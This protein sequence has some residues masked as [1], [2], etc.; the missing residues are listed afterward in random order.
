MADEGDDTVT[1]STAEDLEF[2]EQWWTTLKPL[3]P[4]P[5]SADAKAKE[6]INLADSSGATSSMPNANESTFEDEDDAWNH[7]PSR[8]STQAWAEAQELREFLGDMARMEEYWAEKDRAVAQEQQKAKAAQEWDD[9]AMYEA[10]EESKAPPKRRRMVAR[11]FAGDQPINTAPAS[12]H[13]V[14]I[15]HSGVIQLQLHF[16]DNDGVDSDASTRRLSTGDWPEGV[17]QGQPGVTFDSLT[18]A[19]PVPGDGDVPV[20]AGALGAGGVGAVDPGLGPGDPSG[21]LSANTLLE[22]ST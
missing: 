4:P 17:L 8:S 18:M 16:G 6:V 1:E 22:S 5:Y 7:T 15:P 10:M 14:P 3:L 2:I 11:I 12:S 21:E 19:S 20:D 13:E 9:W